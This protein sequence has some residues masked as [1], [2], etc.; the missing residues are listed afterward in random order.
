MPVRSSEIFG[1]LLPGTAKLY[2]KC[3]NSGFLWRDFLLALLKDLLLCY[4]AYYADYNMHK[5]WTTATD[6]QL[7]DLCVS[8]GH[9]GEPCKNS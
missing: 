4:I 2:P 3:L 5:M 7:R 1:A 8:V 6:V 9:T